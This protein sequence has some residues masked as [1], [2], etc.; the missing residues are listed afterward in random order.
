MILFKCA[1]GLP[2]M[3]PDGSGGRQ[4]NCGGCGALLTVPAESDP[5]CVLIYRNGLPEEGQVLT[6]EQ[7]QGMVDA[8]GLKANDL[9]WY[10]D[11]WMPLGEVFEMPDAGALAPV[12]GPELA[13]HLAELP[14]MPL[15]GV[16]PTP[17]PVPKSKPKKA[18]RIRPR[19]KIKFTLFRQFD[20]P[21]AKKRTV[22]V[23]VAYYAAVVVV[24]ILG[25]NLGLGKILNYALHRPAYV[26]VCNG[27][28][29]D[30]DVRLLGQEKW[31][32]A[33]GSTVFQ[34]LYVSGTRHKTLE[35]AKSGGGEVLKRV[36]VPI[37]P[38]MDVVVNLD[39]KQEFAVFD[40][41]A[42]GKLRLPGKDIANLEEEL[43]TGKDPSS[44]FSLSSKIR[45]LAAPLLLERKTDEIITS[46]QYDLSK[47][48]IFRSSDYLA[49]TTA[50]AQKAAE[51]AKKDAEKA[52]DAG[53]AV[54]AA[55]EVETETPK[56]I[57]LPKVQQELKFQNVTLQYDPD[58]PRNDFSLNLDFKKAFQPMAV[59]THVETRDETIE[60]KTGRK[61]T[62]TTVKTTVKT[63]INP[64]KGKTVAKVTFAKDKLEVSFSLPGKV[65][66]K[67]RKSYNGNW[68]YYASMALAGKD[69]DNWRWNWK[70]TDTGKKKELT[71]DQSGKVKST[72]K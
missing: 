27:G 43:S 16:A 68:S 56:R 1:C 24:L 47:M 40:L 13:M 7:F 8:G 62:K 23:Q 5:D 30:Y 57:L 19:K 45:G 42:V 33:G 20:Q 49:R 48:P 9:I 15:D 59:K 17:L 29:E 3:A 65:E 67:G 46:H 36:K 6:V 35:V 64:I 31:V 2:V 4:C 14:P 55:K 52:K 12:S 50:K 11:I 34:D 71:V 70:F 72:A 51:K 39:S 10:Q 38:G 53:T 37:K 69:K 58:K 44:V 63:T 18:R 61:I 54:P 32:S 25:Y 22:L 41:A 21:G 28:S 60:K 26:L 66:E